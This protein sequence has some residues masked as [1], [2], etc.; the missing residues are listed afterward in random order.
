MCLGLETEAERVVT[1]GGEQAAD[2]PGVT[3][4]GRV[5]RVAELYI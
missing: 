4:K 1:G 3:E 2:S 5:T